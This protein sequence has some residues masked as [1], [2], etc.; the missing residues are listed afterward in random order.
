MYFWNEN[1]HS[2]SSIRKATYYNTYLL[3]SCKHTRDLFGEGIAIHLQSTRFFF[4]FC[5]RKGLQ[6]IFLH[7]PS[8]TNIVLQSDIP[9]KKI[10]VQVQ[11]LYVLEKDESLSSNLFMTRGESMPHNGHHLCIINSMW[12]L[13]ALLLL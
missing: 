12:Y 2:Q 8:H 4:L 10:S 5:A 13:L 3:T 6:K 1:M 9:P 7:I 11:R